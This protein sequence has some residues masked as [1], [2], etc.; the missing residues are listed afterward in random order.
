MRLS[1]S[2]AATALLATAF[3]ACATPG[4]SRSTRGLNPMTVERSAESVFDRYQIPVQERMLDR[5]VRS[6]TFLVEKVWPAALAAER[7]YCGVDTEGNPFDR[8]ADVEMSIRLD[9][10]TSR[11]SLS[12]EGQ[13]V[14]EGEEGVPCRLKREFAQELLAAVAGV[15]LE[16][17]GLGGLQG[18]VGLP[19]TTPPGTR[20]PGGL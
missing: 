12:G 2:F 6:G 11:I 10:R 17:D 19:G 3:A 14:K 16:P 7:L 4:T 9:I 13:R 5:E 1:R 15:P 18:G 8:V 20:P